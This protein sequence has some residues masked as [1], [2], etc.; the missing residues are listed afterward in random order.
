MC[1]RWKSNY[2]HDMAECYREPDWELAVKRGFF[3]FFQSDFSCVNLSLDAVKKTGTFDVQSFRFNYEVIIMLFWR[4]IMRNYNNQPW[5]KAQNQPW[6]QHH[7]W[8][9]PVD[10]TDKNTNSFYAKGHWNT[11][12]LLFFDLGTH[13]VTLSVPETLLRAS[14]AFW[15]WPIVANHTDFSVEKEIKAWARQD[16]LIVNIWTDAQIELS[17]CFS[18]APG[19]GGTLRNAT[20]TFRGKKKK[21]GFRQIGEVR[22]IYYEFIR[23][24]TLQSISTF[25]DEDMC[26]QGYSRQSVRLTTSSMYLLQW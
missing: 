7:L 18:K 4:L 1:A 25:A 3:T 6:P 12:L 13:L 8:L 22:S 20:G 5:K 21:R 10:K 11:P 24:L 9:A 26:V 15:Y 16:C 19:I 14:Q 17:P 2:S 23:K